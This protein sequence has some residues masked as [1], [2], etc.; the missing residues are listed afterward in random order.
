[1]SKETQVLVAGCGSIGQRH[2][3]NLLALGLRPRA[4]RAIGR[5]ELDAGIRDEVAVCADWSQ[6]LSPAPDAVI[7]ANP[8]SHHVQTALGAARAGCHLLVEKPLSHNMKGI[9]DL[10]KEVR[11]RKLVTLMGCNLRFHP[12]LQRVARLLSNQAIGDVLSARAEAGSY[13]PDWRPGQDHTHSYSAREELGGGVILDLV[14]ELDYLFWFF[15]KVK[16]V[17]A[18]AGHGARLG[19]ETEGMAEILMEHDNGVWSSLHLDYFQRPPRRTCHIIGE[20]GTITWDYYA[21]AVS[22]WQAGNDQW[23]TWSDPIDRNYT[24]LAEMRHFL[25]CLEGRATSINDIITGREVLKVALA[26]RRSAS[27]G[28]KIAPDDIR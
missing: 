6:A 15:G 7:I 18:L 2:L 25:D 3:R 11:R 16:S 9:D 20:K 10:T 27:T 4:Y 14:H 12:G 19:I 8:T 5:C 17:F 23:Q 28:E 1:M 21:G 24:Y 22:L 26:A 13:L